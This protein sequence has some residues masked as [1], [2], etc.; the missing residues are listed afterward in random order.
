VRSIVIISVSVCLCVCL[1]VH[2]HIWRITRPI[3]TKFSTDLDITCAWPWLDPPLTACSEIRYVLPVLWM[4]LFSYNAGNRPDLNTTRTVCSVR[5]V[6]AAGAKSAVSDSILLIK[7]FRHKL[8]SQ[9]QT[10]TEEQVCIYLLSMAKQYCCLTGCVQ[11][12][13]AAISNIWS[14][15][16]FILFLCLCRRHYVFGLS[17][18]RV[19]LFVPFFVRIDILIPIS[20]ERLEQF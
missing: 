9:S 20:H 4:T 18:R 14:I 16:L 5:Q 3:F 8:C 15:Y 11:G 19:R 17:V 10:A 2:S 13:L 1:S 7:K 6:A 12:T